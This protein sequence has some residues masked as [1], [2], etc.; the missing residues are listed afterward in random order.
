MELVCQ[1]H[2]R[3]MGLA[4]TALLRRQKVT[5]VV[6]PITPSEL[7]TDAHKEDIT[8]QKIILA[9]PNVSRYICN[10]QRESF[11]APKPESAFED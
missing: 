2:A 11:S 1:E 6:G 4:L 10:A 3:K 9:N 5:D 8:P 7:R